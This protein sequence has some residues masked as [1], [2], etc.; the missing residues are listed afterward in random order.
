[1]LPLL[2]IVAQSPVAVGFW[3]SST[4]EE[5]VAVS[6]AE[7][8]VHQVDEEPVEYGVDV[9]FPIH[10]KK[11]STNYAWLPHNMDPTTPTP[12]EFTDMPIQP[13]GDKQSYYDDFLE[14]CVKA[15]GKQGKRCI[16]TES[17]R[18]EMALRQPQSM[19]NYTEL[20]YKKIRAPPHVFGLI[21]KFWDTNKENPQEE[22]WGV[23]NTYT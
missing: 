22:K 6:D 11:V 12:S 7:P 15:F 13:L 19:Q 2:A 14:G 3:S 21:K 8:I 17:D 20:G 18:I 16:S 5:G 4:E 10:R 1:L 9:S 23:G